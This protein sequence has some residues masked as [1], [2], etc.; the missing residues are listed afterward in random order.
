MFG[1]N[2][3]EVKCFQRG[4]VDLARGW[5]RGSSGCERVSVQTFFWEVGDD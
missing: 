4:A 5:K 2:P 1:T 3:S